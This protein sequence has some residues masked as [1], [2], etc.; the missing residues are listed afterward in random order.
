MRA[1]TRERCAASRYTKIIEIAHRFRGVPRTNV[2]F[3]LSLPVSLT[4]LLP[5]RVTLNVLN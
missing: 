4:R 1:C 5:R 3:H 2:Y